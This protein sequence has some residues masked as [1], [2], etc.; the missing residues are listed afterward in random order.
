LKTAPHI[1]GMIGRRP[2]G[3][4]PPSLTARIETSRAWHLAAVIQRRVVVVSCAKSSRVC[5][6]PPP[7]SRQAT[8]AAS[9]TRTWTTSR[10]DVVPAR[11]QHRRPSSPSYCSVPVVLRRHA[12]RRAGLARAQALPNE[13]VAAPAVLLAPSER[14]RR[15][16]ITSPT[17]SRRITPLVPMAT[18]DLPF[19]D[20]LGGRKTSANHSWR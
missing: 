18:S 9:H 5:Y 14:V 16:P 6:C 20:D 7:C 17:P 1:Y 13:A 19:Q 3:L 4:P 8:A 11:G 15:T 2:G 12:G 10:H